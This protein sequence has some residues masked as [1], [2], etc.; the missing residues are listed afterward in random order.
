MSPVPAYAQ[1]S[2]RST[3]CTGVVH[4]LEL[5]WEPTLA[6][7]CHQSPQLT[8]QFTVAVAHSI[9]LDKCVMACLHY[10]SFVHNNCINLTILLALLIYPWLWGTV[11][12]MGNVAQPRLGKPVGSEVG[13]QDPHPWT[14]SPLGNQACIVPRLL[15]DLLLLKLSHPE[16]SKCLLSIFIFL[17]SG[18][19]L[20][21][22]EHSRFDHF[23][24]Y[25][26]NIL[27][28][29][30]QCQPLLC[31]QRITTQNKPLH[32]KGGHSLM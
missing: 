28:W 10:C 26:A 30:I 25:I 2:P 19:D 24:F 29:C 12:S 23:S 14:G 32:S 16:A 7:H 11:P 9:G 18:L 3:S 6:H 13:R 5:V 4:E 27:L 1:S 20:P 8:S 15:W 22:M 21:G 17:K 31:L